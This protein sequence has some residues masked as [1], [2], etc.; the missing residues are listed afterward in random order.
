MPH[1]EAA[2][3][4]GD[5]V[6]GLA[7]RCDGPEDAAE[8]E[9]VARGAVRVA[10][11][12]LPAARGAAVSRGGGESASAAPPRAPRAR[13]TS[14]CAGSSPSRRPSARTSCGSRRSPPPASARA[15]TLCGQPHVARARAR[16][17][18]HLHDPVRLNKQVLRL[19]V[20]VHNGGP[21]VV[22]VHHAQRRLLHHRHAPLPRQLQRRVSSVLRAARARAFACVERNGHKG[23]ALAEAAPAA[24]VRA[25]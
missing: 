23:R 25:P 22:Q 17:A 12:H 2:L 6:P 8:G 10:A 13:C 5:L 4:G 14:G 18:P 3:R 24:S 16:A 9:D 15:S 11:Q 7:H 20:V 1:V 19:Q 21:H